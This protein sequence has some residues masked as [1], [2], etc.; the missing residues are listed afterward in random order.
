MPKYVDDYTSRKHQM[1]LSKLQSPM[2]TK[3]LHENYE[4]CS[5]V[6]LPRSSL[7]SHYLDF[8]QKS[9][10]EPVNAASFGKVIRNTFPTLKTR[11]LGTRGQSKYHYYGISV[12]E[13]S[14][15][16][17]SVCNSTRQSV[18]GFNQTYSKQATDENV[19][20]SSAKNNGQ[21]AQLTAVSNSVLLPDFPSADSIGI[22]D[23]KTKEKIKTFLIMYRAHCQRILDTILRANFSE[24]QHF[25][26]H[27]WR[28]MPQHIAVILDIKDVIELIANCDNILYKAVSGVL[29]PGTLQPL[30]ASLT[31]AIRQFAKQ[32]CSWLETSLRHVPESLSDKKLTVAKAFCQILCRQTSLSHLAQAA[33]TVLHSTD[34]VSQMAED[35]R[36]VKV[37]TII[38]QTLW[39]TSKRPEKDFKQ[40]YSYFDE[41]AS[42]LEQQATVDQYTDWVSGLVNRCVIKPSEQEE[43]SFQSCAQNFLLIWSFVCSKV[44]QELTL[45]SAKSFGSFHLLQMLFDDY[46]FYLIESHAIVSEDAEDSSYEFSIIRNRISDNTDFRMYNESLYTDLNQKPRSFQSAHLGRGVLPSDTQEERDIANIQSAMALPC[47]FLPSS[48]VLHPAHFPC[49]SSM[50]QSEPAYSGFVPYSGREQGITE[51]SGLTYYEDRVSSNSRPYKQQF[52][53]GGQGFN[54]PFLTQ[55]LER[56]HMSYGT[57]NLFDRNY[58]FQRELRA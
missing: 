12:K 26:L 33:R 34:P 56:L 52:E 32:L 36:Q 57:E 49:E 15:Y 16:H 17:D 27:F 6:S 7:Y 11:R 9:G 29:I 2:T 3:W 31:Q 22:K 53:L 13:S 41:F 20:V 55:E 23:P 4:I 48:R 14:P 44:I 1:S 51:E 58:F 54:G 39:M 42:L 47:T 28:G 8:C 24:V 40:I 43:K 30:P 21:S 50:H 25:L 37:S 10:L 46:I 18:S 5:G 19:Q 35:L 45:R 38:E